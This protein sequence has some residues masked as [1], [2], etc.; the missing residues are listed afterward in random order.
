MPPLLALIASAYGA[1]YGIFPIAWIVFAAIM[2]YRLAVDTGKFEIIKHSVGSLTDDRRLQA[3]FIAFSSG[4]PFRGCGRV[5][6]MA[7]LGP[8]LRREQRRP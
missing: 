1:A 6:P 8:L 2:L 7:R 4:T 3:L 5:C